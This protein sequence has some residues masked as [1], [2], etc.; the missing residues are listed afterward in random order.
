MKSRN[1]RFGCDCIAQE[2]ADAFGIELNKDVI[3]R[4]LDKHYRPNGTGT[5]GPSW[6][7][8]IGQANDSLSGRR[9]LPMRVNLAAKL[10]GEDCHGRLHAPDHRLWR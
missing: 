4:V 5:D 9:P 10:L 7:T 6:L 8:F 3:R 1:P 2:I